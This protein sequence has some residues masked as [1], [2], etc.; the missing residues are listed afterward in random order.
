MNENAVILVGNVLL[1]LANTFKNTKK[2]KIKTGPVLD[3][4][5]GTGSAISADPDLGPAKL[6]PRI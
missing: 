5:S 3:P 4:G 6:D 1:G 2:K